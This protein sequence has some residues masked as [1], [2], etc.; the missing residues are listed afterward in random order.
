MAIN[1]C[2]FEQIRKQ[3]EMG[4]NSHNGDDH[5]TLGK[6]DKRGGKDKTSLVGDPFSVDE[7]Q[8]KRESAVPESKRR[9]SRAFG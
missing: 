1:R 3:Q 4:K 7:I 2:I 6:E 8:A 5:Y 9:V